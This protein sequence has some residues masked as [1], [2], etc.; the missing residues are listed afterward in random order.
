MIKIEKLNKKYR[1]RKT[2]N[3]RALKNID[4]FLVNLVLTFQDIDQ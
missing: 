4:V 1:S 3:Y 2:K